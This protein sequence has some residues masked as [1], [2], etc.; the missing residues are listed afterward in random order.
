[1]GRGLSPATEAVEGEIARYRT[2]IVRT[3]LS[4]PM[5]LLAR[6]G[7]MEGSATVLDFGCGHGDD[8]RALRECGVEAVGWDPH[9][10]P[11]GDRPPSDVVN[12]GFVLNV[13]ESADERL[14]TLRRAW[15][16]CRHVLA[17]AVI[18]ASHR[19]ASLAPFADGFVT[20][21][22]TFQR[23]FAP[24]ELR[25]MVLA[26]TE[27]EP[28]A[29]APG[30]VFAFREPDVEREFLFRRQV[31]R[32]PR[33]VD[34][35]A[36]A[37]GREAPR[38]PVAQRLRVE[39]DALRRTMLAL[40][41]TPA[42]PELPDGVA[43]EL[44]A[45]KVGLARAVG[46][47][48]GDLEDQAAFREAAAARRED[49]VLYFALATFS[50]SRAFGELPAPL[51][52]DVRAFF[53][54]LR[55]LRDEARSFLFSLGDP[56]IL[57]AASGRAVSAGVAHRLSPTAVHLHRERRD[58]LPSQLRGLIGCASVVFGDL[59]DANLLVLDVGKRRVS[60][61][62]LA[63][64]DARLPLVERIVTIDLGRRDYRDRRMDEAGRHVLLHRSRYAVDDAERAERRSTER[65]IRALLGLEP[66]VLSVSQSK[67][68]AGLRGGPAAGAS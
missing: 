1:M 50:G 53:G 9:F 49:L 30:V 40:G 19:P 15:S 52:R 5:K 55:Q 33:P 39:L 59:D 16:L 21:R 17:V 35:R 34:T 46:W 24:E 22:R 7:L 43:S 3:R 61:I 38:E 14:D 11:D 60:L 66:E 54:G 20:A 4:T 63:D 68:V 32:T 28:V 23:Y 36:H 2:A 29:M 64:F 37:G 42:E 10:A 62:F 67:V 57:E 41:R 18:G 8:V 12:L 47:C 56:G 27:R 13:I 51:Q 6:H 48:L 44:A 26:A 65:R 45:A 25:A 31:R 58:D